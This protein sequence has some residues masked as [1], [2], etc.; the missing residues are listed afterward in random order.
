VFYASNGQPRSLS[1]IYS[2]FA[3]KLDRGAAAGGATGI[4]SDGFDDSFNAAARAWSDGDNEVVLGNNAVDSDRHWVQNTLAQLNVSR[5]A[6]G[7]V[8][9]PLGRRIDPLRPTP[10]NARL[11]YLMLANL[12]A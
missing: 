1:E 3:G 2:R 11:A 10:E 7:S 6:G 8:T 5:P 12:G 4:A 9:D